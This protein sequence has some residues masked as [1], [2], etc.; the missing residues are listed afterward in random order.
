[1]VC[2]VKA[3]GF[4]C[5]HVWMWKLD[6]KESWGLKNWCFWTVVLEKTLES[7][8][9]SRENQ[10]VNPKWDQFWILIGWTDAEA[11]TPIH[12]P[13][14]LALFLGKEHD[15]GKDW[16][17]EEKGTTEDEMAGWH[18]RLNGR[19]SEWT[20]GLVMYRKAWHAAIH[21]VTK[22]RTRL[23]DWTEQNWTDS[24]VRLPWRLLLLFLICFSHVRLCATP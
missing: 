21:G 20:P 12:W 17:Q 22:S 5:S 19:E 8:L 11:E 3:Y 15:A 4:S 14:D 1:M 6:H 18:P 9:D 2:L 23:S 10:P 24:R 16:R 13:T 7:S